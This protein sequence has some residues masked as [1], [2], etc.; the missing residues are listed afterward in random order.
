MRSFVFG[1]GE[2]LSR[3]A[4][5]TWPMDGRDWGDADDEVSIRTIHRAIDLGIDVIDTAPAYGPAHAEEVLGRALEG[6]RDRVFLASKCGVRWN[7]VH[8]YQDLSYASVREECENSLQRL[9]T[10]VIDLMQVHWPHAESPLEDTMR[11][12]SELKQEGKIRHIG[13][14]NF[15]VEQME[16]ARSYAEVVA[17]QPPY[18]L[19]FRG[20]E[21]SVLP[22]CARNDL[23]TLVYGPLCKGLLTGKF[24]SKPIPED[25]RRKDPF[26]GDEVLPALLAVVGRLADVA[27]DAGM[28]TGQLALAYT[29]TRP[30]VSCAIVGA[31]T[32]EQI[33]ETAQ[34]G[35]I[36]LPDDIL[37]AVGACLAE[38]PFVV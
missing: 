31:R 20:A 24:L 6:R 22:Y 25:I 9:R 11:A 27:C 37:E 35:E 17:V 1:E 7:D 23:A 18:H 34:A 38:A 8:Y 15:T 12:L 3:I 32:P 13:V 26:F 2:E 30:G 29:L 14:S 33:E 19:F 36:D 10:D 4:L 28:T 21:E 5:G 16:E